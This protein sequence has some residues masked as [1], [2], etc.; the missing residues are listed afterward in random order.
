MSV[1]NTVTLNDD[2]VVKTFTHKQHY[3]AEVYAYTKLR[4]ATPKL[5]DHDPQRLTITVERLPTAAQLTWWK[6]LDLLTDL[7]KRIHADGVNHCDVHVENIVCEPVKGPLLIDWELH[8]RN[9]NQ[10]SYDLYGPQTSRVPQPYGQRGPA[11][12]IGTQHPKSVGV[13]WKQ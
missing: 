11:M 12:W 2:S 5:L 3:L 10:H 1:R 7:L 13:A 6:P 9:V 8:T 4:Y